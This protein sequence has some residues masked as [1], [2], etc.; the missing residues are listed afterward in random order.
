MPSKKLLLRSIGIFPLVFAVLL[1][2]TEL[3]II[4]ASGAAPQIEQG[5]LAGAD[6]VRLFYRKLGKGSDFVVFLHGGP[7]LSMHDGGFA[8]DPLASDHA[9]IMYDQRGGGRSELVKDKRLVTAAADVR[10]LE[11]VRKHFG[12][13]KMTLIGLSWG[14]GLAALYA[15]AHPDRV[16]R[17]VFLDPMPVA[18]NPFAKE[19]SEKIASVVT[20]ADKKRFE[21]LEQQEKV[22]SD[23]QFLS[24]CREEDRLFFK[25]YLFDIASYD[26]NRRDACADPPAAIRNASFV[27]D[28]VVS[29]L[30]DFDLRPTLSRLRVP[31]LVVEGEK[32]NVPLDSTR[33]WAAATEGA[34]LLLIRNAGHAT[35]IEQPEELCRNL[36]IFLS[37]EWPPAS[38]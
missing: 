2:A 28:S 14:S 16:S 1:S 7:G 19:R 17:I 24:I 37:G 33:Q 34:R 13:S 3:Q 31:V 38:Q 22:A 18:L 32:T 26:R 10:D 20:T 12:I 5:F 25:P 11:A 29:S 4:R 9:L 23:D 15:D 21:E 30:G 8:M 27:F 35:F 36:Q 6:G